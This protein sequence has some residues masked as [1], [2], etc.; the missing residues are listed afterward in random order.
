MAVLWV[1]LGGDAT[2]FIL[3]GG[4]CRLSTFVCTSFP[5]FIPAAHSMQDSTL[6]L[7]LIEQ[8]NVV[9]TLYAIRRQPTCADLLDVTD[10]K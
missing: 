5:C 8:H 4:S 7:I 2:C 9:Q 6:I 1:Q 3:H 10:L